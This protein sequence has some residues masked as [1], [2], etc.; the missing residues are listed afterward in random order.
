MNLNFALL[1]SLAWP[2]DPRPATQN[3]SSTNVSRNL[4]KNTLVSLKL[5]AQKLI[6]VTLNKY[7]A[8]QLR[9]LP[10]LL[11]FPIN[12]KDFDIVYL[13]FYWIIALKST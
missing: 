5:C 1:A 4:T 7:K 3:H 12:I 13:A 6:H 2:A 11:L 8:S 10:N 9:K